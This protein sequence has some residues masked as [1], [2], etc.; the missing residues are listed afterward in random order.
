MNEVQVKHRYYSNW[1]KHQP[2]FNSSNWKLSSVKVIQKMCWLLGLNQEIDK[3]F[4][5]NFDK[6]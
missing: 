6:F 3:S 1:Y 2:T 4:E 5:E